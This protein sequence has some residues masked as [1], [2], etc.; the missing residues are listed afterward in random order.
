MFVLIICGHSVFGDSTRTLFY[1]AQ[2]DFKKNI[3]DEFLYQ[4]WITS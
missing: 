2:G 3:Y 4:G 1:T